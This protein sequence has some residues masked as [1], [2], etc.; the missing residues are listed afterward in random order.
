VENKEIDIISSVQE[1]V[2]LSDAINDPELDEA[3]SFVVKLIEKPDIPVG[4]AVKSIVKLE[5]IAAKFAFAQAYYKTFGKAGTDERYKK[6]VYYT[7]REAVI[8]L[9]DALKYIARSQEARW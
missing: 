9:V 5:A 3:M 2:K 8:R 7:A 4:I 6:D 1:F